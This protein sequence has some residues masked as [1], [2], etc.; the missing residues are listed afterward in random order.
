MVQYN[1]IPLPALLWE[2][3][4]LPLTAVTTE[5][6]TLAGQCQ[7]LYHLPYSRAKYMNNEDTKAQRQSFLYTD[8]S[9]NFSLCSLFLAGSCEHN[10]ETLNSVK[11]GELLDQLRVSKK[12]STQL[13]V[14]TLVL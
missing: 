2:I 7:A 4:G 14:Y 5:P 6:S 10:I 9:A 13:D 8:F 3:Y 11:C 1:K 12:K